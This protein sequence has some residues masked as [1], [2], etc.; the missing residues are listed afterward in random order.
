MKPDNWKLSWFRS[1]KLVPDGKRVKT[2]DGEYIKIGQ[3]QRQVPVLGYNRHFTIR[4]V[5][6]DD[7][8]GSWR[9]RVPRSVIKANP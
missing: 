7:P 2:A 9:S 8:R 4:S 1:L 3:E 5:G 6:E